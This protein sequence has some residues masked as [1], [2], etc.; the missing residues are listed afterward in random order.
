MPDLTL[1]LTLRVFSATGGIEKVA[2]AA[3]MALHELQRGQAEE[4]LQIF[5][6]YDDNGDANETYF[7]ASMFKGFGKNKFLFVLAA[8]RKGVNSK[9]VILS[10]A[11][12][13]LPGFLIKIFSPKTRLVLMA[14]G[15]EVWY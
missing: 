14:H 10:H 6:M 5:S 7:P 3:G 9:Q 4:T 8:I 13:L 12:L 1:F 11:N 2:R 15:I